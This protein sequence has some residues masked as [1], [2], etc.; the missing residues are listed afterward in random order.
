MKPETSSTGRTVALYARVS[1][2]DRQQEDNQ[3]RELRDYCR[4]RRWVVA[5]EYIDQESGTV[6]DRQAFKRLFAHAHPLKFDTVLFWALDRFSREGVHETLNYLKQLEDTGVSFKSYTE[7]YLDTLGPF[8]DAVIGIL[9]SLAKQ[10]VIR[11]SERVRAGMARTKAQGKRISRSPIPPV[12]QREIIRLY[13]D[14]T[15]KREIARRLS[16]DPKT[17]RNY[18]KAAVE[19]DSG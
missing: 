11:R 7:P 13:R 3:L 14:R 12:T 18:L 17:I 8:R 10:E 16:L 15:S 4:K 5:G 1:T 6:A 9:A 2:K 19:K